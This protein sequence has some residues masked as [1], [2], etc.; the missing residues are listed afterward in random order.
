M[1]GYQASISN[2]GFKQIFEVNVLLL[3]LKISGGRQSGCI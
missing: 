2:N 3:R 1:Q